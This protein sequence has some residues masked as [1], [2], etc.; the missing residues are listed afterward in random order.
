VGELARRQLAL[1]L[2][3]DEEG[4]QRPSRNHPHR[5]MVLYVHL[6]QD[7]L[8]GWT[9]RGHQPITAGQVRDWC[10]TAAKVT[11]KPVLD[12]TAH[13]PV[14]SPTVPDRHRELV[15]VRDQTCVFPWCTRP[16]RSS[17]CDHIVP[18]ARGGPTCPCNLAALC[19][20]HHRAK[21]HASWTYTTL[22]PG[23][24]LWRSPHGYQYLRDPSGTQDITPP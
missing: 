15:A 14:D 23:T 11:I 6:A 20:S 5:H 19:R 12:P 8:T 17:D 24:H 4:A 9:E 21:T 2:S 18:A 10:G 1:D 7:A 22:E 3:V 13:D 16:A